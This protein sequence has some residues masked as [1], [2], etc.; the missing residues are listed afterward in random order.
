MY[1]SLLPIFD[2]ELTLFGHKITKKCKPPMTPKKYVSWEIE[3][4][5]LL[6]DKASSLNILSPK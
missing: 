6:R 4:V 2:L 1:L 3:F 5:P